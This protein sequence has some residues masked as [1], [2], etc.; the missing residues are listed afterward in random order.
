[1]KKDIHPEYVDT[2]VTCTCGASFTTRSTAT[3]G[4]IH[5]DIGWI[6]QLRRRRCAAVTAK[7]LTAVSSDG[8]DLFGR[9]IH[10]ANALIAAVGDV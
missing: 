9:C 6:V 8:A 7:A 1:M 5:A 3:S 10:F 2:A 4:S